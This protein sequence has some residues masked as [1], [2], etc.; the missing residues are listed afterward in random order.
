MQAL[1]ST[2]FMINSFQKAF[3]GMAFADKDGDGFCDENELEKLVDHVM[4][5]NN[6]KQRQDD[7][8]SRST[9]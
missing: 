1:S 6:A 7:K 3:Y 4:R 5:F 2:G 8:S 9:K